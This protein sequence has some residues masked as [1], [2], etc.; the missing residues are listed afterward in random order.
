MT[1]RAAE[2]IKVKNFNVTD[3]AVVAIRRT[4]PSGR[5]ASAALL[6]LTLTLGIGGCSHSR[7]QTANSAQ[8]SLSQSQ[9]A[10]VVA[11][12]VPAAQPASLPETAQKK[13]VKRPVKKLAATRTY[14]DAVSGLSFTYPRKSTLEV[15]DKAEQDGVVAEQLPM[16]FVQPNGVTVAVIELPGIAK[17]GGDFT[18]AFFTISVNQDLTAGECEQFA[19]QYSADKADSADKAALSPTAS[20]L[21]MGKFEY[22][23]LDKL[24]D[25]GAVKYYHRY[26]QGATPDDNACYEFAMSVNSPEQKQ[27]DSAPASSDVEHKDLADKA[28]FARLE[29][30]LASVNIKGDKGE[31]VVADKADGTKDD[32]TKDAKSEAP[33][34]EAAKTATTLDQNPR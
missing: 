8:N 19:G 14:T 22:V 32:Q 28:A 30:I 18:P 26:V 29:K 13:S 27:A 21:T 7:Q 3:S 11:P 33:T 1:A 16:N 20:K 4:G 24:T 5:A 25:H 31:A 34:A 23:E 15:G 17:T 6:T 9:S 10:Q 2:V 12:A